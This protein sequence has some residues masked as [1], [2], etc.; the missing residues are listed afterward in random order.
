[1]SDPTGEFSLAAT[2]NCLV[3]SVP[4]DYFDPFLPSLDVTV[5]EQSLQLTMGVN[6]EC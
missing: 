4:D 3:D 2:S 6:K 5:E 1:M